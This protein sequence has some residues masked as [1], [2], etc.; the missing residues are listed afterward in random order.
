VEELAGTLWIVATPIG[1]LGDLSPRVA[2]VLEHAEVILAE[3][4]R[5]ARRLLSHLGIGARGRLRSLHEHNEA[6]E[7]PRVVAALVE[8][9]RVALVS[10]AGTPVLSDPGFELVRAARQA[11]VRVASVPGPSAFTAALAASGQPPLPATLVGFLPRRQGARRRRVTELAATPWTLVIL[12]SPH[13][14]QA[15]LEDLAGGLGADAPATLLAE[16]SKVHERAVTGCLGDLARGAGVASVRGEYVLV[17]G[18]RPASNRQAG[19]P[20]AAEVSRAYEAAVAA[21]ATRREA[22]AAVADR[23][24]LSRREVYARLL[25]AGGARRPGTTPVSGR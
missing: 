10:D 14:L 18:P 23:S 1:T 6:Q 25:E 22:I 7:V 15:E 2:E 8:G 13:R 17:V 9:R 21:G 12:L 4:T 24:G 20:D 3:D 16:I 5:R 11:G 19:V